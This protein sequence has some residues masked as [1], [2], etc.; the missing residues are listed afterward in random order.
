MQA[1]AT[2]LLAQ[3]DT[4]HMPTARVTM[5]AG[6]LHRQAWELA[7]VDERFWPSATAPSARGTRSVDSGTM[8]SHLPQLLS[9]DT[10]HGEDL[11]QALA[12]V[13]EVQAI[14]VRLDREPHR[15]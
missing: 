13:A 14:E 12:F 7:T 1:A 3:S 15:H 5:L 10:A 9:P 6:L 2:D 4:L 11:L 8:Q